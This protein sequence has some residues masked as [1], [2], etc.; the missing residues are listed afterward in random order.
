MAKL[1]GKDFFNSA[2]SMII[3]RRMTLSKVSVFTLLKNLKFDSLPT[4]LF[5]MYFL[6]RKKKKEEIKKKNTSPLVCNKV[7]LLQKNL[8]L[9]SWTI[10]RFLFSSYMLYCSYYHNFFLFDWIISLSYLLAYGV[11]VNLH[12]ELALKKTWSTDRL[13]LLNK[14]WTMRG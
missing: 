10:L 5:F 12:K 14:E 8:Y 2:M 13:F 7:N 11:L 9:L 3:I 1:N 6:E 4:S